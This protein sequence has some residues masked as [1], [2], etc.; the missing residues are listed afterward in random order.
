MTLS[1]FVQCAVC[2]T[3]S[4]STMYFM[5]KY[6]S[7]KMYEVALWKTARHSFQKYAYFIEVSLHHCG[8]WSSDVFSRSVCI[9]EY[10]RSFQT[11]RRHWVCLSLSCLLC[12][13]FCSLSRDIRS[14]TQ[15]SL[16]QCTNVWI[17]TVLLDRAVKPCMK[18]NGNKHF[19]IF[20]VGQSEGCPAM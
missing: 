5:Y 7:I 19:G 15:E 13:Y 2:S 14:W 20:T 9:Y 8:L 17:R 4:F 10:F 18:I 3:I 6:V 11:V 12:L 1:V 16:F